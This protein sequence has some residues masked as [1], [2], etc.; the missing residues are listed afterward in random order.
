LAVDPPALATNGA[1]K[2]RK[3]NP[4]K[5]KQMRER[6]TFVEEEIPRIEAAISHTE[7]SLGN[8]VSM[9]ETQRLTTLL[10]H[11]REQHATLNVEWEELMMQLEEQTSV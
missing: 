3:L 9:D 6:L 1:E 10:E 2:I 11:L 4:I 7:S 8:Y 5:L